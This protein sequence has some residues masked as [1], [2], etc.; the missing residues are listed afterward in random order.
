MLNSF[1]LHS[2]FSFLYLPPPIPSLAMAQLGVFGSFVNQN[3][4]S[5]DGTP[6][7]TLPSHLCSET[8][9]RYVLWN[10]VQDTFHGVVLL[11]INWGQKAQ[12]MINKHGELYVSFCLFLSLA[13]HG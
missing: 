3:F 7:G 8:G 6:L 13:R 10:D 12:F 9:Q 1:A 5:K 2:L 11:E 4:R